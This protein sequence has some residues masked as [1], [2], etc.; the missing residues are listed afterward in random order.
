[1]LPVCSGDSTPHPHPHQIGGFVGDFVKAAVKLPFANSKSTDVFYFL[2]THGCVQAALD[3][4]TWYDVEFD[5]TTLVKHTTL[6]TQEATA[7]SLHAILHERNSF[8]NQTLK[9]RLD[10]VKVNVVA[11]ISGN[12]V[13]LGIEVDLVSRPALLPSVIRCVVDRGVLSQILCDAVTHVN[14]ACVT[15]ILSNFGPMGTDPSHFDW[16]LAY[17]RNNTELGDQYRRN[18]INEQFRRW[19][20]PSLPRWRTPGFVIQEML[21]FF[22][23]RE[24]VKKK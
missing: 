23:R 10:A 13:D 18:Q 22:L 19:V 16:F 7:T 14:V 4:L 11:T 1:M 3:W 21:R 5:L 2:L 17:N 20:T 12:H 8:E 6:E 9:Q 15:T 24:P